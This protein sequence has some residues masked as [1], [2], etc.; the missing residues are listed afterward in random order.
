MLA[1]QDSGVQMCSRACSSAKIG[2][3]QVWSDHRYTAV[4]S[5]C[6]SPRV[7]GPQLTCPG[8]QRRAN[9][10]VVT[11][12]RAC[13]GRTHP[14]R[15]LSNLDST[16]PL[17]WPGSSM[18]MVA[19]SPIACRRPTHAAGAEPLGAGIATPERCRP[20]LGGGRPAPL[21]WT[22]E[23]PRH[24]LRGGR[25]VR[26]AWTWEGPQLEQLCGAPPAGK[27]VHRRR[28]C[29]GT[30]IW[31]LQVHLGLEAAFSVHREA[32]HLW[33]SAERAPAGSSMRAHGTPCPAARHH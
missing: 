33:S 9:Q 28:Q 18:E 11:T 32:N 22:W 26:S 17:A 19:G 7:A 15:L 6:R 10:L 23:G 14:A 24:H 8:A 4:A 3:T 1:S 16:P 21:A 31:L 29:P 30:Q 12:L 25:P 2:M 27:G 5:E 13:Q 20:L